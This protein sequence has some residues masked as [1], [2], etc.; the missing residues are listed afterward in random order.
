MSIDS[1]WVSP[2]LTYPRGIARVGW[3]SDDGAVGRRVDGNCLLG[4][5]VEQ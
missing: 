4:E 2:S 5:P 1:K 3:F